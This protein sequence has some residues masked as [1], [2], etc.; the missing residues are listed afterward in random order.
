MSF[1][2]MPTKRKA[3]PKKT[4]T[5]LTLSDQ[6]R[7]GGKILARSRGTNLTQLVERM[8]R[9]ELVKAGKLPPDAV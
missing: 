7:E 8:L 5:T 2:T 3:K 1:L 9:E 6:A 4:T